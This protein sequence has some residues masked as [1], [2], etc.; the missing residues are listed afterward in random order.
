MQHAAGATDCADD[1]LHEP[2]RQV[3]APAEQHGPF[4]SLAASKSTVQSGECHLRRMTPTP[5]QSTWHMRHLHRQVC[6]PSA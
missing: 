5:S 6:A 4:H 1:V 2:L 3:P